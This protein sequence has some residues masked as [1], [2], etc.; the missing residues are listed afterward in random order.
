MVR[1]SFHHSNVVGDSS[2]TN[3]SISYGILDLCRHLMFARHYHILII[4][5]WIKNIRFTSLWNINF[6]I[7]ETF[8]IISATATKRIKVV[9]WQQIEK[10]GLSQQIQKWIK[11]FRFRYCCDKKLSIKESDICE[12]IVI[13][14][15]INNIISTI[16]QT[17]SYQWQNSH[18]SPQ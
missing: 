8:I 14:I 6:M 9:N 7:M 1:P 3:N 17:T 10:V 5:K 18:N 2:C 16:C 15:G 12:E 4:W 13:V 11:N